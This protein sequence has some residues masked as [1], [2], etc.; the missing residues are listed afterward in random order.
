MA[1]LP[2]DKVISQCHWTGPE[3][4][5]QDMKEPETRPG[6]V[7]V[8]KGKIT[9]VEL[10]RCYACGALKQGYTVKIMWNGILP[11]EEVHMNRG[12]IEEENYIINYS[13][14][15]YRHRTI[16]TKGDR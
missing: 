12:Q 10:H 5:T 14:G 9:A 2:G 4:W 15:I 3:V 6:P 11:A 1:F 16:T 7:E 8:K 13:S